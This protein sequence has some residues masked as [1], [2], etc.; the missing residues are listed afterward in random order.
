MANEKRLARELQN[1]V[2]NKEPGF[3]VFYDQE[4]VFDAKPAIYIKFT[5]AAGLYEGQTHILRF[6]M[7]YKRDGEQHNFPFQPPS[8][9][10]ITH[11]LHANIGAEGGI[12]LDTLKEKWIPVMSILSVYQTIIV[13]LDT[14]NNESPLNANGIFNNMDTARGRTTEYY[15]KNINDSTI[16]SILHH[17]SWTDL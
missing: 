10:F 9:R 12:C 15:K 4:C 6:N 13:L 1:L 8:A 11:I 17:P 14:P 3:H 2:N 16:Q 7:Q 5:V